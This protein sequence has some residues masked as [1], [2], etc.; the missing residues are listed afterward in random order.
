MFALWFPNPVFETAQSGQ[1]AVR[2]II[3]QI[4]SMRTYSWKMKLLWNIRRLK[5]KSQLLRTPLPDDKIPAKADLF[6]VN[7]ETFSRQYFSQWECYMRDG[8]AHVQIHYER[9]NDIRSSK[10]TRKWLYFSRRTLL[11]CHGKAFS[12]L[13]WIRPNRNSLLTTSVGTVRSWRGM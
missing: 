4:I 7:A 3:A 13:D 12:Y 1:L 6:R 9:C 11:I 10:N 2:Q 5:L 8:G